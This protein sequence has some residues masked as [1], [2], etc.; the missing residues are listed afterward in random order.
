MAAKTGSDMES[1]ARRLKSVVVTLGAQG[2]R[3]H[4]NGRVLE[5]PVAPARA[6]RD[7]T[8]CG[9]AY[10][11]GLLFGLVHG[12]DWPTTGRLAAV[13]GALKIEQEGAQRHTATRAQIEERFLEAFGY[14][15]W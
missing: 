14:R 1:L 6:V 4:V 10:R 15:P 3:I 12:L 5:I 13:M 2:S 11:A 7:P 9:D 8:G